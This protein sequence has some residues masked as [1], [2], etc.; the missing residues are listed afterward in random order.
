MRESIAL[1]GLLF[2]LVLLSACSGGISAQSASST[3]HEASGPTMGTHWKV[4]W[5]DESTSLSYELLR[6]KLVAELDRINALMSTWD[7][8]SQLSQ[9]NSAD[10]IEPVALH[11]DTL[12][13]IDTALRISQLTGGRYDITLQPVI[14]LWG[15]GRSEPSKT[16]DQT[17][18]DV[19]L[20]SSGYQQLVRVNDTVR[21]RIPGMSIDVSSLAKGFAVDRLGQIVE[22][23]GITRYLVDIGGELRARGQ[24]EGGGAW[25]VGIESP[26]GDVPQILNLVDAHI[27][28][29]GSYRNFRI[30]NGQ[31]LS[32]IIDGETGRP[33]T[34][35]VVSVSVM[36]ESAM[37]ADAWAT[38]LLVVGEEAALTIIEQHG[39]VAQLTVFRKDSFERVARNGFD[40]LLVRE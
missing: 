39:L 19:A 16:P 36:H 28:S 15:F 11:S 7:P 2:I 22:S 30:E 38:A 8:D 29:S 34:H 37:L 6:T 27:A 20:Q 14:D 33:I 4:V 26:E 35:D 21:R 18:I 31:R 17:D 24:R 25:R 9:F 10:T 32:H 23:L 40:E 12:N 5:V 3:T 13:V 1:I